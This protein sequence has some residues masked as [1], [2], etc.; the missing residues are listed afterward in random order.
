MR[1]PVTMKLLLIWGDMY[2]TSCYNETPVN[3]RDMYENSC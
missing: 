3:M 2:E 1:P